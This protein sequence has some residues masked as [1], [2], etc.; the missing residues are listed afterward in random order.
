MAQGAAMAIEDA[1]VL[2]RCLSGGEDISMALTRYED[3]RRDRTGRIQMDSRRNA[4][5]FHLSGMKAWLRN[6]ALKVAGTRT[7]DRLFS[8]NALEVSNP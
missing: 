5:V 8:Y 7:M 2:A 4:T 1:A 6:R 3:L